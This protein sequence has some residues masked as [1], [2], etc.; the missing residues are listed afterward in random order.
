MTIA[1]WVRSAPC[2]CIHRPILL[3]PSRLIIWLVVRERFILCGKGPSSRSLHP[4]RL[5]DVTSKVMFS[6]IAFLSPH[7]CCETIC[8]VRCVVWLHAFILICRVT[9]LLLIR[10]IVSLIWP[11]H[12][13][14]NSLRIDCHRWSNDCTVFMLPDCAVTLSVG[15]ICVILFPIEV[16]HLL[17]H[18]SIFAC[19]EGVRGYLRRLISKVSWHGW[20]DEIFISEVAD[21]GNWSSVFPYL[22]SIFDPMCGYLGRVAIRKVTASVYDD[23]L[24]ILGFPSSLFTFLNPPCWQASLTWP[25]TRPACNCH[26]VIWAW[27]LLITYIEK[28]SHV[29]EHSLFENLCWVKFR[30]TQLRTVIDRGRSQISPQVK[31]CLTLLTR[32]PV[33]RSA[34]SDFS[35]ALTNFALLP[36][37]ILKFFWGSYWHHR[38]HVH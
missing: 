32:R 1:N 33:G 30:L 8:L 10:L 25:W 15:L 14:L 31:S 3:I 7:V 2:D 4:S 21:V 22:S 18:H 28:L 23:L 37:L 24:S 36:E 6:F 13:F 12:S 9:E 27:F 11:C 35:E 34:I 19:D 38:L 20:V 5:S 17:S 29:W 26:P 16:F